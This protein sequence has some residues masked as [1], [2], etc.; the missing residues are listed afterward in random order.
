MQIDVSFLPA[1]AA[2]FMLTFARI[3]TMVML[4]PGLGELTVSPRVRLTIALVLTAVIMPLH[5]DD[6]Q[7]DLRD[8]WPVLLMLGQELLI[9]AVLGLLA[10]LTMASLQV[11]GSVVAQQMGLGFVTA[12]DPSQGQQGMIV[13][14]F[15]GVLGITLIFATDLHHLVIAALNDSYVLFRPGEVPVLGD[16]AQVLT[17]TVASTFRIGV[18]LSAPFL[19]FGLLFNLGL[20]V[21]ARLM[22]QMQVYFVGLPLS[23]MIGFLVLLLVVGAMMMTFLGH[24]EDVLI[25]LAPRS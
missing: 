9:G 4:L 11:A 15:L 10:R 3:G 2:A 14:N 25:F 23:I 1:Y 6:Y 13:G 12:I 21:L 18:Q 24:V 8:F 17:N 7:L 16:V 22:P 20:G 5:R 19:V